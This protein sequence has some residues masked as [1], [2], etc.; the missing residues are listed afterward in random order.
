LSDMRFLRAALLK[1]SDYAVRARAGQ[2]PT[3]RGIDD[4]PSG[5]G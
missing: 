3:P 1:G 4:G 5:I 2:P